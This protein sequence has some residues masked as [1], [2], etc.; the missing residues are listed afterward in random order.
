MDNNKAP[1]PSAP[2]APS[3]DVAESA[4]TAPKPEAAVPESPVEAPAK[5]A[6]LPSINTE[7]ASKAVSDYTNQAVGKL[8]E[9]SSNPKVVAAIYAVAGLLIIAVLG[10]ALYW[11]VNRTVNKRISY[12]FPETETPILGTEIT[13]LY[14][15]KVPNTSNGKRQTVAFWVFLNDVSKYRGQYRH[16]WHRGDRADNYEKASPSVYLDKESNKMHITFG[17]EK[18]NVFHPITL[19]TGSDATDDQ[20]YALLRK[21]RGITIDYIPLQRWVHVAVVVNEDVNGGTI[22]SYVDG[23]LVSVAKS[24]DEAVMS[25]S[26]TDTQP[27]RLSIQNSNLNKKGNVYVG[28]SSTDPEIGPGFSGLV[29]RIVFFNYDLNSKDIYNEY[30]KGPVNPMAAKIGYGVQAPIYRIG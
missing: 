13:T 10:M 14:A 15:D 7:A 22:T 19:T 9:L 16:I 1:S 24:E 21:L 12:R 3:P 30:L 28:G 27:V 6:S 20:K 23:E 5:A 26:S 4:K 11:L 17:T 18:S 25:V 2:P 29:S 8:S